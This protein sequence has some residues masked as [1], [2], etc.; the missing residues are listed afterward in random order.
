MDPIVFSCYYTVFEYYLAM[1][2]YI[3]T[4]SDWNKVFYNI[5]HN[6][7]KIYDMVEEFIYQSIDFKSLYKKTEYWQRLGF[8]AGSLF[9][10]FLEDPKNY[11]PFDPS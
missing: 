8:L 2:L 1:G 5:A 6:L 3:N 11:Y 4:I 7:G 10:A 9:Q